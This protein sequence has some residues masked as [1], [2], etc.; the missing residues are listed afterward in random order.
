MALYFPDF[1]TAGFA[2]VPKRARHMGYQVRMTRG[3]HI[4]SLQCVQAAAPVAKPEAAAPAET[5]GPYKMAVVDGYFKD[6]RWIEGNWDFAQFQGKDGETDWDAVI[7]AEMQRRKILEDTPLPS[8]L[9]SPV[10]FDTSM[11]PWW[12]WVKRFHLPEAEKLNGRA[13]MV[14]YLLAG[15]VDLSSGAGLVEQQVCTP[16]PPIH[17]LSILRTRR[18]ATAAPCYCGF[19]TSALAFS[20]GSLQGEDESKFM[21]SAGVLPGQDSI[22]PS[23]VWSAPHSL[24]VRCREVQKP[25]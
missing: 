7:D 14:G 19:H 22:A 5:S 20:L 9:D 2:R 10:N 13:A 17:T 4:Q 25:D 23:R 16:R 3:F 12:A 18:V 21:C 24:G 1:F 8:R 6:D 11:V 15:I